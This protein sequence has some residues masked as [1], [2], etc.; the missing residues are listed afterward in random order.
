MSKSAILNQELRREINS[1]KQK[2]MLADGIT[3][4][5]ESFKKVFNGVVKKKVATH[6]SAIQPKTE[7]T[8]S[9]FADKII[10]P[11]IKESVNNDPHSAMIKDLI[12]QI[13]PS[14]I[15]SIDAANK[16]SIISNSSPIASPISSP[17][18]SLLNPVIN[19]TVR[20]EI[21]KHPFKDAIKANINNF[22]KEFLPMIQD[23]INKESGIVANSTEKFIESK[24]K[25]QQGE[26]I[27]KM[28]SNTLLVTGQFASE[29]S[30]SS[31]KLI[32]SETKDKIDNHPFRDI[33]SQF[34]NNVVPKL[35]QLVSKIIIVGGETGGK[36]IEG[37]VEKSIPGDTGK[38]IGTAVENAI[39]DVSHKLA[40]NIS[41]MTIHEEH[42]T[43]ILGAD[44]H[45]S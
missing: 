30:S 42:T 16:S 34:L 13:T 44:I 31:T 22:V 40:D 8:N 33:I 32:D 36:F 27:A 4:I 18:N 37:V 43:M 3:D 39:E 11:V 10:D 17:A 2:H 26:E 19:E 24:I 45:H 14:L 28:V 1:H 7:Q 5:A 20:V 25:G 38:K 35:L 9:T 41:A 6:A 21:N 15:A 12:S 23:F 29:A